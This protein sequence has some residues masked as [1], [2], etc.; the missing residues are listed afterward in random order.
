MNSINL[1]TKPNKIILSIL[2][3]TVSRRGLNFALFF[4]CLNPLLSFSQSTC[5]KVFSDMSSFNKAMTA[6][7]TLHPHQ[8][9]LFDLYRYS[10]FE[11]SKPHLKHN[12]NDIMRVWKKHPE[13][14]KLPL[15]EHI[16]LIKN[17]SYKTPDQ[18]SQLIKSLS[19]SAGRV[20]NNLF[21]IRENLGYWKTLLD[22]PP[23]DKKNQNKIEKQKHN[24]SFLNHLSSLISK[25]DFLVLDS[26]S[27]SHKQKSLLLYKILN[28]ARDLNLQQNKETKR[29]SQA[30]VDIIHISGF[31]NEQYKI[32]LKH[33]NPEIQL[34]T[35]SKII[36]ERDIL[37]KKLG[38]SDFL[39]LQNHFNIDYPTGLSKNQDILSILNRLNQK[40][41]NKKSSNTET[42]RV[43]P[44]SLQE[45][46]FRS[47]MGR[48]CA[49]GQEF[50]VALD[51]NFHYFTLTNIHNRSSGQVTVVLGSAK[52]NNKKIQTAFVDKI[53][54]IPPSAILP[55][56]ESIRL[57]LKEQGYTLGILTNSKDH[58]SVSNQLEISNYIDNKISPHLKNILIAFTP[59]ENKYYF[60]ST[61]SRAYNQLNLLEFA[62]PPEMTEKLIIT[63]GE[64]QKQTWAPKDLN[65][66][67]LLKETLKLQHSKKEKDQIQFIT[68]LS[69]LYKIKEA[70]ISLDFTENYLYKKIT[71]TSLSFK[72]RKFALFYWI[73]FL[74]KTENHLNHKDFLNALKYFSKKEEKIIL[75]EISNWK[76]S[77]NVY[78]REFIYNLTIDFF[79][80][81]VKNKKLL[82]SQLKYIIDIN[83]KNQLDGS[84]PLMDLS[85]KGKVSAI[86]LL[87]KYKPDI[88]VK[89]MSDETALF[90]SAEQ[91]NVQIVQLLIEQGADVNT[92]N[93][94]G[95][96]PLITAMY[97]IYPEKIA[98]VLIKNKADIHAKN[99]LG[100]TALIKA[101]KQGQT[102]TAKQLIE[103]GADINIANNNGDTPLIMAIQHGSIEIAFMLIEQGA[104]INITNNAGDTPLI[105]AASNGYIEIVQKL[106]EY[107]ADPSPRNAYGE[108]ALQAATAQR[109]R[110]IAQK[111]IEY[112][113]EN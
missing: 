9:S 52:K 113:A 82:N 10:T 16:I 61:L 73:E 75:G 13:L 99:I 64:I 83:S 74:E 105:T 37:A 84:T 15:R 23:L 38:F 54:N 30:M 24:L 26:S 68:S 111:L 48:D 67:L 28:K 91:G 59:H 50:E 35:L 90:L 27:S 3:I 89:N 1:F 110:K 108:T 70:N 106:I 33:K 72:I 65:P 66:Q 103:H 44:L 93:I 88:H 53:Q 97:N 57:S 95:N 43:R 36:K 58:S 17:I 7:L 71:D 19:Q 29:I 8:E 39:E 78:K 2:K 14:A 51:P 92:K 18:L 85:K 20:K 25:Q 77:F 34:E 22:F 42:L 102:K 45:S 79:Q 100:S 56:L 94:L 21:K 46:P 69:S 49:S 62:L 87:M 60:Q 107:D 55:M 12:F 6:N 101:A 96:T 5:E 76:K 63:P 81:A 104:D 98:Q 32:M 109:Y 40:M 47:C 112:S 41:K 4:F 11:D 86:R 80:S 31:N